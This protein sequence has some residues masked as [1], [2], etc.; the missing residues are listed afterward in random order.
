MRPA[1]SLII[2]FHA[3][4][5][6][7]QACI[8]S[9]LAST[10]NDDE[11]IVVANNVNEHALELPDFGLRVQVL[12]ISQSLGYA[13]ASNMG[14]AKAQ[15]NHLVF[16]DHDLVFE[17][18][19]LEHLWLSYSAHSD[20]GASSCKAI[21]PHSSAILDFGIAFSAFNGAHPGLDLPQSHP[22]V[23]EDRLAQAICTS[24]FLI[25]AN[26]F[27]A[28]GKFD[29][30]FGSMYTDLDLCLQL[31]RI[32]LKVVSS[33]KALAYHFGGDT[34]LAG[35][36]AYKASSL[37]ADIKGAFMRKHADVLE[38]DLGYY[39]SIAIQNHIA[40][41]G[42]LKK[43]L[44]CNMMNVADP[45]WYEEQVLKRGMLSYESITIASGLRDASSLGL[46]ETLGFNIMQSNVR[47]AYFVDRFSSLRGN[48]YWWKRRAGCDDLI[49]DR[50]ANV[51]KI[52]AILRKW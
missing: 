40:E 9:V 16:C 17:P 38:F 2:V 6:Y 51:L 49:V 36:K 25:S 30:S 28:A 4:V 13:G 19:W 32:G 39:Y 33:A 52:D 46:F 43:Y 15:R 5:S 34:H 27:Q 24:G 14:A 8:E 18:D 26:D 1:F 47:I 11:I 20:I 35:D 41:H 42:P 21:N 7:L 37:K 29:V 50:N 31:K 3:G 10:N 44:C 45:D 22:L 48:E 23:Q 12:K